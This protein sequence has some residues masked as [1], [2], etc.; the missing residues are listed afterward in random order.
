M[1]DKKKQKEEPQR[2]KPNETKYYH[3]DEEA[4]HVDK[5]VQVGGFKNRQDYLRHLLRQDRKQNR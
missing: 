3:T 2:K 4:E 5:R 1:T